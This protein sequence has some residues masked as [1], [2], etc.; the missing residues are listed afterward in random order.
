MYY[1]FGK[2][3]FGK[4]LVLILILFETRYVSLSMTEKRSAEMLGHRCP[5]I[6]KGLKV[7]TIDTFHNHCS[8]KLS[9]KLS[10]TF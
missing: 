7:C 3:A 2:R 10:L 9:R 6:V 4:F 5:I 8:Y 1:V